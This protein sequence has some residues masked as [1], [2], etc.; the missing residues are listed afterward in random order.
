VPGSEAAGDGCSAGGPGQV[1]P[2]KRQARVELTLRFRIE[3]AVVAGWLAGWLAASSAICFLSDKQQKK[4]KKK[5]QASATHTL[6]SR[7][8]VLLLEEETI[9]F[10]SFVE[11]CRRDH[12]PLLQHFFCTYRRK[13]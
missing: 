5:T 4:F 9:C 10:F 1:D 11:L 2:R 12:H 3:R 8:W 13:L 6:I 7:H